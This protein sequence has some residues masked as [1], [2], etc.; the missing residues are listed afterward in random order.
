MLS[1]QIVTTTQL[2]LIIMVKANCVSVTKE[3][4]RVGGEKWKSLL[5]SDKTQ[6]NRQ[7]ILYIC[8]FLASGGFLSA[9]G[10]QMR[11]F[12]VIQTILL[13]PRADCCTSCAMYA[14]YVITVVLYQFLYN[15][16]V[17]CQLCYTLF[18]MIWGIWGIWVV[19]PYHLDN[20]VFKQSPKKAL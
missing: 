18:S 2:K 14:S 9:A 17:K 4:Q 16:Y 19:H 1:R 12:A 3:R 15:S 13:G 7:R 8:F 5:R 20:S 6:G 10:N 11:F